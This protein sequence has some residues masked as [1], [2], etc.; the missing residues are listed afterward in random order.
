MDYSKI[1]IT[2]L[3]DLPQTSTLRL[4]TSLGGNNTN[5]NWVFVATRSAAFEITTGTPTSNAGETTAINFDAAY[6]LDAPI[7]STTTQTVNAL[8]IVTQTEGF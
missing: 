7:T 5:H 2:F 3:I 4:T 8:E 6:T 1:T